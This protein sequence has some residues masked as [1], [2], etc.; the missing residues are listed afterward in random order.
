MNII[1]YVDE[2]VLLAPTVHVLKLTLGFFLIQYALFFRSKVIFKSHATMCSNTKIEK[3][4]TNVKIDKQV[5]KTVTECKHL[6][7]VLSNDLSCTKDV[8]RA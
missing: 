5:L 8:K 6:C 3:K 2:I 4:N 1:S 7:V